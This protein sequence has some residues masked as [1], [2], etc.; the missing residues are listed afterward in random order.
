MVLL[1]ISLPPPLG[2]EGRGEG[3]H[4]AVIG[5]ETTG[6]YAWHRPPCPPSSRP[7]PP[8]RV[9]REVWKC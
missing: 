8:E 7:S 4:L 1:N 2:G 5:D 6:A 3:G 9:E